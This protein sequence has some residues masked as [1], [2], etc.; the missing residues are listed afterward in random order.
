MTQWTY[1]I[2]G[3]GIDHARVVVMEVVLG[4]GVQEDVHVCADMKV[5]ELEGPG[6][7]EDQ[8]DIFWFVGFL[9]GM[10]DEGRWALGDAAG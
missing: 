1:T 2:S 6:E 9:V 10:C 8:G 7:G 3:A 4:L 5:R